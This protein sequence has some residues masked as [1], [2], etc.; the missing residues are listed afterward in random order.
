MKNKHKFDD[1]KFNKESSKA[2]V[3]FIFIVREIKELAS[4]A[5]QSMLEKFRLSIVLKLNIMYFFRMFSVFITLNLF[6]A[7]ATGAFVIARTEQSLDKQLYS[8]SNYIT[9]EKITSNKSVNKDTK[10]VLGLLNKYDSTNVSIYD[11]KNKLIYKNSTIKG[12]KLESPTKC[13]KIDI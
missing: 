3:V 11:N 7:V 5:Y 8:Y 10:K 6:M 12:E 9:E 1:I 13:T 4:N 2:S